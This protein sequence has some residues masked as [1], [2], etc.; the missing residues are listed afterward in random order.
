MISFFATKNFLGSIIRGKQI[1]EYTGGKYNPKE[2]FQKD[3]K[4][5]LKPITLDHIKGGDWVDVSD[6]P[7][8]VDLLRV[9]PDIK[10]ITNSLVSYE[11]AKSQ[12]TNHVIYL[13]Q[14]H[15]NWERQKRDRK[16]VTVCGYIGSP[17]PVALK[18]YGEIR[19]VLKTIGVEFK[20]CF[21]WRS[22]EDAVNFYKSID[23]LI[24]GIWRRDRAYKTPTKLINAASFGVPSIADKLEGY[25]EFEG[26]YIPFVS[27]DNMLK[28]VTKLKDEKYYNSFAKK[29]SKKAEEY[30]ID[31]I[32]KQYLELE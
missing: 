10:V 31:R 21:D 13:P 24:V 30:H 15:L 12:L 32:A 26:Y 9:R 5:Y 1:A 11:Y 18:I 22:R 6:G 25:E 19:E 3:I 8:V 23:V 7:W 14:Q 28:E 20:T 4:V 29:I 17:S 27:I 16:G 2:D